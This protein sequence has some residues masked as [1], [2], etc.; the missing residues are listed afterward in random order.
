LTMAG[1]L[2]VTATAL[3]LVRSNAWLVTM[4]PVA[5]VLLHQGYVGR[6]RGRSER[7]EGRRLVD[8]VRA[9]QHLDESRVVRQT[10]SAVGELLSADRVEVVLLPVGAQQAASL[11][12]YSPRDGEHGA[13]AEHQSR[14]AATAKLDADGEESLGEIRVYFDGEVRLTERERAA[15][16]T[17]AAGARS[18]LVAARAHA[19]TA[20]LAELRAYEAT[21]DR[22]TGLPTRPL[23]VER[24]DAQLST[25][26]EAGAAVI[27]LQVTDFAEMARTLGHAARD[28]LLVHA[29]GVLRDA[30]TAGEL[31]ARTDSDEFAVFMPDAGDPAA[32]GRRAES[33]LDALALPCRVDAGTI[34]L[35]GAAGVAYCTPGTADAGELLR[36]ATVALGRN[37]PLDVRVEFYRAELDA[38]AGPSALLLG[39]Q[40][41]AALDDDWQLYLEYQPMLDVATGAP[42][43]AEALVRWHHPTRPGIRPDEFLPVL[44]QSSLYT[45]YT[46]W[47]L[48][49]ALAERAAWAKLELQVPVSVN[50]AARS[51]LDRTLP[52]RVA[53]A[54]LKAGV[55][56]DR[57]MLELTD[58]A[59]LSTMSVVDAVLEDLH[60]LGVRLAIDDFGA[61][62][63]SLTRLV[64]IPATH[65]KIAP[66]IVDGMLN[67]P[68]EHTIARAAIEIARSYDLKVIAVGAR[69]SSHIAAVRD[70]GAHAVQGD[71]VL[72]PMLG[73][74][75]R[76]ALHL[77][78]SGAELVPTAD[79]IPLRRPRPRPGG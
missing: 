17:L 63:T 25:R 26:S 5:A 64:R 41:R 13:N 18:S 55:S 22:L 53:A 27:V 59:T 29:A 45:A 77:A 44:E 33:L 14:A 16:A 7:A 76:V 9:M 37:R 38:A 34:R 10:A 43:G 21:H 4:M 75:V 35:D 78:A 71:A 74:K 20:R 19:A 60:E 1:N 62:P 67:S 11:Y 40:L 23:L 2:T 52:S 36:Q 48:A 72:P 56:A 79:V 51:L 73:A 61:G 58:S 39:A 47:L 50:L 42:I 6:L 24:A 66:E 54:L 15:L 28:Q 46:D 70:A 8:A 32:A 57:L 31:L 65:L 68:Q 3:V 30:S 69:T 49:T 12:A